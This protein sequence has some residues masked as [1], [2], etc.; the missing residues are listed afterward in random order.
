MCSAKDAFSSFKQYCAFT[1]LFL[2][3][4]LLMSG[5]T[6]LDFSRK[7]YHV[8][9]DTA[10]LAALDPSSGP[11]NSTSTIRYDL[12]LN[13][14][15]RNHD[16][17]SIW[18]REIAAAVFYNGTMLGVPEKMVAPSGNGRPKDTV[19]WH[20]AFQGTV[21]VYSSVAAELERERQEGLVHVQI[22]VS[23]RLARKLWPFPMFIYG[24]YDCWL[25]LP[26]P[27]DEALPIDAN[28]RCWPRLY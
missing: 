18:Y 5:H 20:I 15:F 6:S 16:H 23:V 3:M 17:I 4:M 27:G 26:T 28:T 14:S 21:A 1:V 25:R 11:P 13:L 8:T 9:V 7:P 10:S 2:V 24:G 22:F 12:F 19:V